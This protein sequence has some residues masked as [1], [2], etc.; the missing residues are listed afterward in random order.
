MLANSMYVR[1]ISHA[2]VKND[3]FDARTLAELLAANLVPRVWISGLPGCSCPSDESQTVQGC[4][5]NTRCSIYP[6]RIIP[7]ITRL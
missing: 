1:A 6:H 3:R 2:K 7:L 4:A 5:Y